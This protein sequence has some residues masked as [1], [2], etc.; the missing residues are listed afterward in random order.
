L[1]IGRA[2]DDVDQIEQRRQR[3]LRIR[4]GRVPT[5]VRNGRAG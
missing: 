5:A 3:L 4:V 1:K 2:K